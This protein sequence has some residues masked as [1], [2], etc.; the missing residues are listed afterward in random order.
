MTQ[1]TTLQGPHEG[2]NENARSAAQALAWGACAMTPLSPAAAWIAGNNMAAAGIAAAFFAAISLAGTRISDVPGQVLVAFGFVGQAMSITAALAG[3]AWQLDAHMLFF[4]LLAATMALSQPTVILTSAAA[5]AVHH[6]SLSI[7]VPALVYPS[8]DLWTNLSRTALH[9]VI[10]VAEAAVLWSALRRR[11]RADEANRSARAAAGEAADEA[12]AS[13]ATAEAEK[14][15]ANEALRQAET[16]K[17]KALEAGQVAEQEAA[18]SVEADR[19]ARALEAEE[20]ERRAASEAEQ[21]LVVD[22]L[23]RALDTLSR[24]DLSQSINETFPDTYE[25]VR[26]TFNAATDA[27]EHAISLVSQNALTITEDV[28]AIEQAAE[29]LAQ[30]TEAQAANLEETSAAITQ[31]SHNSETAADSAKDATKS[32][33]VAR[34][35]ADTSATVVQNAISAM[36]EIEASSGQISN[37]VQLIEDIAFQTNLLALNAGVEAARA[38]EAGRGF[39]VVASEVRDLARRSSEAA[40]EIGGLIEASGKQV[41]SGVALVQGTEIALNEISAAILTISKHVGQIETSA[42]EQARGIFETKN[43]IEQLESVTQQNAAMFEETNAVTRSLARQADEL[44]KAMQRFTTRSA[45]APKAEQSAAQLSKTDAVP[46]TALRTVG[47]I[48]MALP[49]PELSNRE[50]F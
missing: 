33:A 46:V 42:D 37:I 17:Q 34:E 21:T 38:G 18:K 9:G 6:L 28:N 24:G 8:P 36:A 32:V 4:A 30:R 39:S 15:K 25:E 3:H 5:I 48:A 14:R 10:I 2:N 19:K 7:A 31:I 45:K 43:A 35:K 50:D 11:L 16:L 47:N 44:A 20:R 12:R 23:R 26:H 40:Q 13:L 27:L 1:N 41:E 49:E 29:S 22:T